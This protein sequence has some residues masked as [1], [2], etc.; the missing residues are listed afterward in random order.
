VLGWH[1]SGGL[2]AGA[3]LV[4]AGLL[5]GFVLAARSRPGTRAPI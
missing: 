4:A 1:R 3:Q 5:L 2:P